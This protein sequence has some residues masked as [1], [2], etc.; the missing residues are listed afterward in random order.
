MRGGRVVTTLST[1]ELMTY[2]LNEGETFDFSSFRCGKTFFETA[3]PIKKMLD[4]ARGTLNGSDKT[5]ILTAR[6]DL[7][8]KQLFIKKFRDC[9]FPIDRVYIERAGNLGHT[10]NPAKSVGDNKQ[11]IIRQHLDRGV[12]GTVK[13]WDDAVSNLDAFLSLRKEYKKIDFIAFLV[14]TDKGTFRRYK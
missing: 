7:T 1:S 8:D 4:V 14:N 11:T 13:M 12:F 2:R 6:S 10:A 9:N 5:I 3:K